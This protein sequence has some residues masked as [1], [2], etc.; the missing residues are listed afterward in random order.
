MHIE[1]LENPNIRVLKSQSDIMQDY[2]TFL[3]KGFD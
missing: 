2:K 3:T 1:V